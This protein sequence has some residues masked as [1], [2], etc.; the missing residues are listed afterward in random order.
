MCLGLIGLVLRGYVGLFW[1]WPSRLVA[2]MRPLKRRHGVAKIGA[3]SDLFLANFFSS[4]RF[5]L[6]EVEVFFLCLMA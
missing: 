6:C 2:V 1:N 4:G 3:T 5:E